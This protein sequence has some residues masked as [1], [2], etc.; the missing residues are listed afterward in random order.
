MPAEVSLILGIV[1]LL[2]GRKLFWLFIAI[3]GFY[4]GFEVARA[5]LA[6]QPQWLVWLAAAAAGLIGAILAMVFQRVAFGLAGLYAGG[7]LALLAAERFMPGL[8]GPGAFVV[9]AVAG[10]IAAVLIMDWAIIAL[11][12]MFGAAL[13]VSSLG[14]GDIASALTY[15]GLIAAGIIVQARLLRGSPGAEARRDADLR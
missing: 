1:L 9:G 7:Y 5:F 12:C 15:G 11:S 10:A 13:V 4:V 8:A 2:L 14:L 6:D 3:A